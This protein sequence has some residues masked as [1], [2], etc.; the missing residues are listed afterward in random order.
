MTVPPAS[1]PSSPQRFDRYGLIV[2]SQ[3]RSESDPQP[4]ATVDLSAGSA[5]VSPDGRR[6]AY[7]Q[8]LPGGG[9]ARVLWVFDGATVSRPR[10]LLTLPTTETAAVST[11]GGVVWSND[12]AALL[13]GVNS[14]GFET[15]LPV[16]AG[17]FDYAALR[18]VD[19]RSGSVREIARIAKSLPLRPVAFDGTRRV[20]GAVEIGGGGF[21][22][23]YVVA[24]D[25]GTVTRTAIGTD[26]APALG[27]A[28]ATQVLALRVRPAGVLVWSLG[29]PDARMVLDSAPDEH[30]E[31][32]LWRNAREIV[33]LIS[34]DAPAAHRLEVWTVGGGR[35]VVLPLADDLAAVR[36]DGTAAILDGRVVDLDSGAAAAVPGSLGA[37]GAVFA[38]VV[39]FIL[40]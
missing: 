4:I 12:G 16:D 19:V 5:A 3:I 23:G 15:G 27:S 2:G 31:T 26:I 20:A 37:H 28:D 6:V 39:S 18:E 33:V 36:P 7:W 29:A 32:A 21:T 9:Q 10:M 1:S 14:V 13:I 11:G 24:R 35:R 30:V 8:V 38:R 25:D 17:R 34:G 40:R 22:A